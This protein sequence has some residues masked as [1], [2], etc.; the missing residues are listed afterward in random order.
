[1][2]A[3]PFMTLLVEYIV[4]HVHFKRPSYLLRSVCGVCVCARVRHC[5]SLCVCIHMCSCTC[6]TAC[7]YCCICAL[8][9]VCSTV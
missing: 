1:M 2:L 9:C 7:D 6:V 5:V 3:T 4:V 8:A